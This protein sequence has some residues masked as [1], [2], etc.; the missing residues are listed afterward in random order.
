MKLCIVNLI[1]QIMKKKML[2]MMMNVI[3]IL[4]VTE[5]QDLLS[6]KNGNDKNDNEKEA[7]DKPVKKARV[8]EFKAYPKDSYLE[9]ITKQMAGEHPFGDMIAKKICLFNEYYTTEEPL[10]PGNPAT[11][12]IIKK[13]VIYEAVKH[14]DHDLK[15]SVRKRET[16]IDAASAVL[17]KVLDVALNV[18]TEDTKN[19]ENEIESATDIKSEIELFID[20][21]KL[22]Y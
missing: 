15:R 19:L 20:R 21:V 8:F 17:N 22:N 11:K 12:T 6:Y 18:I 9:S 4:N 1:P 10:F 2:F 3:M 5:A 14:I 13:P 16:S 7:T